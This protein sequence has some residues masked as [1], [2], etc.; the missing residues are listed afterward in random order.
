[1]RLKDLTE[2]GLVE[3]NVMATRPVRSEYH[4][5]EAGR[6]LAPVLQAVE[7]WAHDWVAKPHSG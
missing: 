7:D 1:M 5:T 6:A 3:R 4:L 2:A